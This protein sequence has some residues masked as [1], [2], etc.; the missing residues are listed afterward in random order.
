[1]CIKC[2]EFGRHFISR[3]RLLADMGCAWPSPIA[4]LRAGMRWIVVKI[5]LIL[6]Q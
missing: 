3:E 2:R 4:A 5:E 6:S 1:M